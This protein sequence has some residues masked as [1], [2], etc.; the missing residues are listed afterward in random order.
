MKVVINA[1]R[2]VLT[3]AVFLLLLA[4]WVVAW[5][6]QKVATLAMLPWA[7][8]HQIQDV[9]GRIFRTLNMIVMDLLHPMWRTK[10]VKP[11]RPE[12]LPKGRPVIYMFNHL[13]NSDPWTAIRILW[14]IDCKWICKG[15]LF[16]VPFGGWCL[17][18][19]GDL[20]VRFTS[21][22]GGWGTEKGSVKQLMEDAAE[23]LRREQP[24]AVFPEG[25]R[26]YDPE[27][28]LNEF[29]PGFF[30]LAIKEG[31]IIVPIAL[32][33]THRMW[34]RGD[35]KFGFATCYAAV[36]EHIETKGMETEALVKETR[37]TMTAMVNDLPDRKAAAKKQ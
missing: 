27:G 35:W 2:A 12:T 6:C 18:N 34:P 3:V 24:I 9:N 25:V 14:P 26:S 32:S 29:K 1:V 5:V 36:G 10:I 17:E 22:K 23:L 16:K 21:A 37:D 11:F 19:A 28:E 20:A 33:G 7:K 31:A 13:S 8:K 15:S 4:T 30:D